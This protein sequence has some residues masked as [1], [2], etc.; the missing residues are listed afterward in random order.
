MA[1]IKVAGAGATQSDVIKWGTDQATLNQQWSNNDAWGISK[2]TFSIDPDTGSASLV[3]D[4]D[5]DV[6]WS[7]YGEEH[8]AELMQHEA[9]YAAS[10][11]KSPAKGRYQ[12][13]MLV[14][15]RH[16]T[17]LEGGHSVK[18]AGSPS[19][20]NDHGWKRAEVQVFPVND[21]NNGTAYVVQAVYKTDD[22][23][24]ADALESNEQIARYEVLDSDGVI[25]SE[26]IGEYSDDA[27][28]AGLQQAVA[29]ATSDE[30]LAR[31]G[32]AFD[33]NPIA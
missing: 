14:S 17:Q 9:F 18:I 4:V 30:E 22:K 11:G 10:S 12:S 27:G 2:Q 19:S 31:F 29:M 3:E 32:E 1:S 16:I 24:L 8:T 33:P 7:V 25:F 26:S 6:T 28:V 21:P 20:P 5:E 13:G 23:K 15:P